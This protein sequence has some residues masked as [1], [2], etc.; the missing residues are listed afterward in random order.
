MYKLTNSDAVIRLTDN[1][2]IPKDESNNDYRSYLAWVAE[3]NTP[4]PKEPEPKPDPKFVG[5]DFKGTLCS[6]TRDDQNGL[7]AVLVSYQMLKDKF[8]PTKF[9]FANGNTITLNLSNIQEFIAIWMPFRQSF[10]K[11]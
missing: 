3:G 5:I 4:E 8:Q 9:Y 11:D 6:A 10:F 7:M 2:F 1:A